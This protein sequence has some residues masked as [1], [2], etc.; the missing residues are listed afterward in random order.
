[1]NDRTRRFVLTGG[2]LVAAVIITAGVA[3]LWTGGSPA[4]TPAASTGTV[5]TEVARPGTVAQRFITALS[6]GDVPAAAT[7]TDAPDAATAVLGQSKKGMGQAACSARLAPMQ[8]LPEGATSATATAD[9]SWALPG[10]DVWKYTISF[11]VRRSGDSWKVHWAPSV[12]HPQLAEGQTLAYQ[13]ELGDGALIDR[14]GTPVAQWGI[15]PEVL[16]QVKTAVGTLRG[17]DGWKIVAVNSADAPATVLQ[18]KQAKAAATV[19][20]TLGQTFQKAAQAAVESQSKPTM[21]VA[22]Q[23]STGEVLAVAGA[24]ALTGLY[25]PGSTFKVVTAAAVLEQGLATADSVQPCPASIVVGQRTINNAGFGY[26]GLPLHTAFAKSCNTTFVKL[27]SQLPHAT[28]TDVAKQF[29]IGVDFTMAGATTNSG[30]VQPAT[31]DALQVE[32]S[33][34]QGQVR[35]SPFGM[36]VA[37]ATVASG[38][39]VTPMLLRGTETEVGENRSAPPA[40]I[41][42]ALRTM[43]R[44][45]VTNGTGTALGRFGV[46]GKT[47]TAEFGTGGGAHGWF[48]GFQGDLA[49]AVLVENAGSSEPAVAATATFLSNLG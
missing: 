22:M 48:I 7:V 24:Q 14:D 5:R 32:N 23:P 29:G 35:T 38:K 19:T 31:S 45:V 2:A 30:K 27:A 36:A 1:M 13:V 12:L 33:I 11:E 49:F 34:G 40:G 20:T 41:T 17:T 9:V 26:D 16:T 44:E 21:V 39:A 10:A 25:E 46:S 8:P 6:T 28:L 43:M 15:T 37:A 18:E 47:G 3:L 42:R 4:S